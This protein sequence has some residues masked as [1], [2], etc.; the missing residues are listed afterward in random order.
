[1]KHK[2]I[3]QV[4]DSS[5]VWVWAKVPSM[6]NIEGTDRLPAS[7]MR[8]QRRELGVFQTPIS[9]ANKITHLGVVALM[10]F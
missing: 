8:R 10:V 7:C 1:M 2:N 4:V 3:L 9:A 5:G 6:Q